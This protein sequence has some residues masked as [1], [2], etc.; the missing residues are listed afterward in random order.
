MK[1][2]HLFFL[3]T[4]ILV[5]LAILAPAQSA[6]SASKSARTKP[7]ENNSLTANEQSDREIWLNR[8]QKNQKFTGKASWYGNDFHNKATASGVKYDMHTFTAAHRTLPLGTVVKVT[9]QMNGK[10]VMV[11]VTDRG[12]YVGGR[13][14]DLSFAAAE[15]LGLSERG[16]GKVELEVVSDETGKPLQAGQAYFVQYP[17][18]HGKSTVGPF[19]GFAD[20]TAMQEALAQAYPQA[21]VVLE[22]TPDSLAKSLSDAN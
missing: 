2:F 4:A 1:H 10:S 9:D 8:V 16:V 12:P 15:K 13:I 20:A 19:Q 7:A 14:I 21:E 5:S 17:S 11:C 22:R 3:L 18:E 6:F